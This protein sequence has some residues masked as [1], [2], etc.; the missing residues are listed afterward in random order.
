[1]VLKKDPRKDVGDHDESSGFKMTLWDMLA[2]MQKKA[3]KF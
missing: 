1:M 3:T 2:E